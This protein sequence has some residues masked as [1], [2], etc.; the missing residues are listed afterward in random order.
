MVKRWSYSIIQLPSDFTGWIIII[1][2][3]P[4]T[5]NDL[6]F[7]LVHLVRVVI[8]TTS[9]CVRLRQQA[10]LFVTDDSDEGRWRLKFSCQVCISVNVCRL[11]CFCSVC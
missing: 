11:F 2:I 10:R 3:L 7:P 8:N 1:L 9:Q 6:G 5:L 4:L